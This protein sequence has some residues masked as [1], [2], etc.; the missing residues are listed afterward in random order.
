[1]H[2]AV[3]NDMNEQMILNGIDNFYLAITIDNGMS[4]NLTNQIIY[5]M[6]VAKP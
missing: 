2:T 1:M 5:N 3:G 6:T 4:S